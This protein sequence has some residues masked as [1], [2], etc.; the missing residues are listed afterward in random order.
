V[1]VTYFN[2]AGRK[3]RKEQ[4]EGGEERKKGISLY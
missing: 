4:A 3:E 1:F 2:L